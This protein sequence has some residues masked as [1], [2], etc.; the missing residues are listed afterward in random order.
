MKIVE[1]FK[2]FA[3]KGN[4][5]DMAVGIII[6]AA[7]GAIARS[8]ADD[9]IMPPIQ[10]LLSMLNVEN[11]FLV[12][13]HGDPAGPYASLEKASAAGAVTMNFGLF[14]N[15]LISFFIIA[16]VVFFLV[17]AV[18]RLR[19]QEQEKPTSPTDKNCP[20]C[21]SSIAIQATRC[22]HC[23]SELVG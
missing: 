19:E 22:P 17:R 21:Q 2:K 3:V 20:F 7:F 23:T 5:V 14:L 4:V 15:T 6:G 11:L 10:L 1:E 8:L 16:V 12:V 13:K 9:V 18:N